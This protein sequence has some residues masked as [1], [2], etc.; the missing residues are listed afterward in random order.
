VFRVAIGDRRIVSCDDGRVTFSYRK[1][2][3]NRRRKMT[4]DAMEFLRRFLQHVLPSGFPKVRHY[5]LLSP[6]AAVSLD[7]VRWLIALWAGSTYVLHSARA[8]VAAPPGGPTCPGCGGR[9]VWLGIL[10]AAGPSAFDTSSADG[11]SEP[12]PEA[13]ARPATVSRPGRCARRGRDPAVRRYP[14]GRSR[15]AA[16]GCSSPPER[17]EPGRGAAPP[18]IAGPLSRHRR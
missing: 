12:L 7:L 4:P 1:V 16:K 10:P 5:G 9:L 14:A 2:G 6:A 15:R 13:H 3:S 18:P 17:S 8:E 11:I